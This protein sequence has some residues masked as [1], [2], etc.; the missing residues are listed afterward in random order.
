M[1]LDVIEYK[2]ENIEHVFMKNK[3]RTEYYDTSTLIEMDYF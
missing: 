1:L 2:I 3:S